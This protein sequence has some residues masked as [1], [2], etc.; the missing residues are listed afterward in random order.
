MNVTLILSVP[1]YLLYEGA[2][3]ASWIIDRRRTPREEDPTSP[4]AALSAILGSVALWRQTRL[5]RP[6]RPAASRAV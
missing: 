6:L 1:L 3:L 4:V 2:I 5:A